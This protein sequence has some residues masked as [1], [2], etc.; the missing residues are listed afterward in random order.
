MTRDGH[1]TP[2]KRLAA[3]DTHPEMVWLCRQGQPKARYKLFFN[4]GST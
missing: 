4:T 2:T 3:G 1:R